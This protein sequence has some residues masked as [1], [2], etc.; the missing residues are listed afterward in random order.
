MWRSRVARDEKEDG[1]GREKGRCEGER[2]RVDGGREWEITWRLS[3]CK[4][5]TGTRS[6]PSIHKA[7]IPR[8]FAINPV[9]IVC[10]VQG[11]KEVR[12]EG[13]AEDE[14]DGAADGDDVVAVEKSRVRPENEAEYCLLELATDV[15]ETI[16]VGMRH[17][18]DEAKVLDAD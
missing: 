9:L 1:C 7:V 4:T 15:D 6:P 14:V 16:R 11:V 3:S 13:D 10:G 12:G 5:V 2:E 18:E 8:F 17:L